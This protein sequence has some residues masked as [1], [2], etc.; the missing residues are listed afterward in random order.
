MLFVKK[1][2]TRPLTFTPVM[3]QT[4]LR[5]ERGPRDQKVKITE[6]IRGTKKET[7]IFATRV[8]LAVPLPA[9]TEEKKK[10][11]GVYVTKTSKTK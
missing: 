5:M 10:E 9:E 4:A 11:G 3:G 2:W 8:E 1:F 7:E 6:N